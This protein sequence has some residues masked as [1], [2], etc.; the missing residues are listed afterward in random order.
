MITVS[1]VVP[2][3]I[4]E[5]WASVADLASHEQWMA[6]AESIRFEGERRTGVGTVMFVETVVGP[7]RTEDIMIV[8]DW[9]ERSTIEVVHIG[10]VQGTGRFRFRSVPGGTEFEWEEDLHFPLVVGG[11]LTERL[12]RPILRSIW[13]RNLGS[14]AAWF[15][16]VS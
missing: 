13:Q 15:E 10:L 6:D 12:A 1:V 7:L 14:F 16:G 11:A 8:T 9:V 5:V 4:D 3:P 2:A